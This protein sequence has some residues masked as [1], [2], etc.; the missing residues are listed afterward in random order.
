MMFIDAEHAVV[1]LSLSQQGRLLLTNCRGDAV[2]V[3][4]SWKMARTTFGELMR[5]AGV[6][7]PPPE[8][9]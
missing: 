8:T 2:V 3:D 4:G 6:D 9:S 5:M 1:W 7:Y